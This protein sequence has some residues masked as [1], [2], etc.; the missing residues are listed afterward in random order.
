MLSAFLQAL[1]SKLV[2]AIIG[3]LTEWL[4][5]KALRAVPHRA[6]P[7]CPRC[8]GYGVRRWAPGGMWAV[9]LLSLLAFAW[10]FGFTLLGVPI[11]VL[12]VVGAVLSDGVGALWPALLAP[13]GLLVPGALMVG[14]AFG[15]AW[16][17]NYPPK[18]CARCHSRWPRR[19][20]AEYLRS[21]REFTCGCG[22]R[23]RVPTVATGAKLRCPRCR[24][25]H[26]TPLRT[27]P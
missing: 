1:A 18:W 25:E 26:A 27:G 10:G 22:Q 20:R 5:P 9:F 6:A 12:A 17:N 2:E 13:L 16:Y 23:L 7:N 24:I 11:V 4:A 19:D 14:G 21:A 8:G 15:L 3:K